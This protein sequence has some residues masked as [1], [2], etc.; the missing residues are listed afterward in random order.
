M[1]LALRFDQK[2][3]TRETKRIKLTLLAV[4][5]TQD[6]NMTRLPFLELVT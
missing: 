3:L 6:D 2:P 4:G 1:M 5:T